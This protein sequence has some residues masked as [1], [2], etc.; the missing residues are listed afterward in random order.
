MQESGLTKKDLE[1]VLDKKFEQYQGSIIEAVD[2]KFQQMEQKFDGKFQSLEQKF[3]L[4]LQLMEGRMDEKYAKEETVQKLVTT[5]DKFLHRLDK[6]EQEFTLL[7]ADVD[8]IKMI[9]KDKLGVEVAI[10]G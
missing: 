4:K 3:D 5:I 2:W 10:Q 1:E 6:W 8:K 7:K 9:I